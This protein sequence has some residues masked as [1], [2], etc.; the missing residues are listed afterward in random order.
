MA[1]SIKYYC[2]LIFLL[3]SP[4]ILSAQEFNDRVLRYRVLNEEEATC[5][6]VGPIDINIAGDLEIP[7]NITIDEKKYEIVS[8]RAHAFSGSNR[9]SS[10][11]F[12]ESLQKIGDLSFNACFLL[13]EI[14]I[15]ESV[16]YIGKKA[17][18]GCGIKSVYIS[19]SVEYI[20][21][22]AF[23][24]CSKLES[25]IVDLLNSNFIVKDGVLYD[26]NETI[27]I[28]SLPHTTNVKIPDSVIRI[29][30]YAFQGCTLLTSI[31][32]PENIKEIGIGA[33][34]TC[35]SL[36]SIIIPEGI[37]YIT[38]YV[39][40]GCK[41]LEEIVL[42]KSLTRIYN[43]SFSGCTSLTS[44]ILPESIIS[45]RERAFSNCTSLKSVTCLSDN[46]VF[47][48]FGTFL[49]IDKKA[50]LYVKEDLVEIYK[51][52]EWITYFKEILPIPMDDKGGSGIE[53]IAV[54]QDAPFD[55]Y[56]LSG[57]LVRMNAVKMDISGLNPGVYILKQGDASQRIMIR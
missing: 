32:L 1:S 9:L 22:G 39:F 45:L 47:I 21:E 53:S 56:N 6:V 41:S 26:K 40:D 20:G 24:N 28:H 10:V 44:V 29:G 31:E 7:Q 38:D 13:E 15:P 33:F 14:N 12:P 17:F 55:I 46:Y 52:S 4:S 51:E 30:D 19:S 27:L 36:K 35:T 11:A 16:N 34:S 25:I 48:I 43:Y 8:I 5:E 42:P 57:M 3:F 37:E 18:S 50:I 23:A 54:N 49:S 2:L